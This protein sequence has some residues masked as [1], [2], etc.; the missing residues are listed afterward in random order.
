MSREQHL[1]KIMVRFFKH[2]WIIPK[3]SSQLW[4]TILQDLLEPSRKIAEKIRSESVE[5]E[6]EQKATNSQDVKWGNW[7]ISIHLNVRT[8]NKISKDYYLRTS[9]EYKLFTR[10]F[11]KKNYSRW[12]LV[13]WIWRKK[14]IFAPTSLV[15][16]VLTSTEKR[17]LSAY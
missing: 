15:E 4:M 13:W 12:F 1:V 5:K 10:E 8:V 2:S 17:V 9:L 6:D 16:A 11:F 7:P 3:T 14:K